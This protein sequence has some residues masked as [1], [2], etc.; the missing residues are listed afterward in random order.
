MPIK[1]FKSE[2]DLF[3]VQSIFKDRKNLKLSFA[4]FVTSD[5][6]QLTEILVKMKLE[7]VLKLNF[8]KKWF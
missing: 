6:N 5:I 7:K 1:L 2:K 3:F 8:S 4:V